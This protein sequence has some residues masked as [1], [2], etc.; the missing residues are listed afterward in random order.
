[1][2]RDEVMALSD[3]DLVA[4]VAELICMVVEAMRKKGCPFQMRDD[5]GSLAEVRFGESYVDCE[6]DDFR[7]AILQA[8]LL[9]VQSEEPK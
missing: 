5:D 8:A 2:T 1:M 3:T 9:A 4:R 7:K 6:P